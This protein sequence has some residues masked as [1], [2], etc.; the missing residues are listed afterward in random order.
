MRLPQPPLEYLVT[1]SQV[2]LESF[3][4]ARLNRTANLRKEMREILEEWVQMEV[5]ARL[6]RWILECRRSQTGTSH[7]SAPSTLIAASNLAE[8]VG[9]ESELYAQDVSDLSERWRA[10]VQAPVATPAKKCR[11]SKHA[12][13]A[14][15][16]LEQLASRASESPAVP[17]D[18]QKVVKEGNGSSLGCSE[19]REG[20][21]GCGNSSVRAVAGYRSRL[22]AVS[23][24]RPIR[25][26][27]SRHRT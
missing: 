14:L 26:F 9:L 3:E 24:L 23:S 7:L 25:F 8:P 10:D 12:V 5:D 1:S 21:E 18:G 6:A 22:R 19:S 2:A 17:C 15:R 27:G 4:L 16:L 13:A 20:I 11:P